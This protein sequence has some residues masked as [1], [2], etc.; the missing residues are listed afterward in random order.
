MDLPEA[1]FHIDVIIA[2]AAKCDQFHAHI[3]QRLRHEPVHH[4]VHE[5]TD[6]IRAFGQVHCVRAQPGIKKLHLTFRQV[7][8]RSPEYRQRR[9]K[10]LDIIILRVKEYDT[11]RFHLIHSPFCHLLR[12]DCPLSFPDRC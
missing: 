4:I 1:G 8:M 5:D 10:G 2:R 12:K 11:D 3:R 7:R 6:H 9:F